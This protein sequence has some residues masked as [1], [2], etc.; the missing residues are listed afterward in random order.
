[1]IRAA[2]CSRNT[3]RR[4]KREGETLVLVWTKRNR[5]EWVSN[6][7]KRAPF[8]SGAVCDPKGGEPRQASRKPNRLERGTG[9]VSSRDGWELL[10]SITNN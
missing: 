10:D 7:L 8:V 6:V 5:F 1:M 2:D 9:P 3:G 4:K